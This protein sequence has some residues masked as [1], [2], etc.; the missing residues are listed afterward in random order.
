MTGARA[1][2]DALAL[3][4][5]STSNDTCCLCE[6]KVIPFDVFV[7][8]KNDENK[9][10]TECADKIKAYVDHAMESVA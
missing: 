10:C 7:T 3:L 4:R 5:R 2:D 1:I 8:A 6:K 9:L